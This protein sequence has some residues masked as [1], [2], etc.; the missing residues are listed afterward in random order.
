MTITILAITGWIGF[1]W[2]LY[3]RLSD[4]KRL[5]NTPIKRIKPMQIYK[6]LS[7]DERKLLAYH[8]AGHA[9]VSMNMPQRPPLLNIT[10]IPSKLGFGVTQSQAKKTFNDTFISMTSA[11]VVYLSGRLSEEL[12]CN[13]RTTSCYDDLQ[14][15]NQIAKDM[16][17]RFGMG[18]KTGFFMISTDS[19]ETYKSLVDEDII[20]ILNNAKVSA[21]KVLNEHSDDVHKIAKEL[22]EKGTIENFV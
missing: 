12:F 20:E 15:A 3:C 19:S 22:L 14:Q 1:L 9:V 21:L 13:T 8:E 16:V 6:N 4:I 11:I 5:S 7:N 17:T 10:I 18:T 2:I